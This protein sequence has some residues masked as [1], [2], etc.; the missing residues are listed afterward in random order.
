MNRGWVRNEDW[1]QEI[2]GE[3]AMRG[4]REKSQEKTA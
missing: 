4:Q 3:Q 2:G 1:G